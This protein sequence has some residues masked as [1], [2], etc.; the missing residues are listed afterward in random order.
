MTLIPDKY[1]FSIW[2]GATFYET[3]TIY[4]GSTVRDLTN[5]S[6]TMTITKQPKGDILYG[7][8]TSNPTNG[9][10][11]DASK[12]IIYVSIEASATSNFLWKS[13]YYELSITDNLNNVV[14]V[15][16]H[17]NIEVLV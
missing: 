14:D 12:G 6:V 3:L 17:G 1:N 13:G 7:P 16:L 2:R 8:L 4:N 15:I 11:L 10:T 9:I 5:S